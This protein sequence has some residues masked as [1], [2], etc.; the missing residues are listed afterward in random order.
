MRV[1]AISDTHCALDDIGPMLPPGDVLVHAGDLTMRGSL[2]EV[3]HQLHVLAS[4]PYTVKVLVAGNHDWLF[5]RDPTTAQSLLRDVAAS[6]VVYLQDSSHVVDGVHFYGSPWQ[7]RFYDWAFNVDR[8]PAIRAYWD[9]IP[10]G[11]DVLVTHGPPL[12]YGDWVPRGEHVGCADLLD[13]VA[14]VRPRY[15]IFGHIHCDRGVRVGQG[16]VSATTF[17]NAACL[18]DRYDVVPTCGI[19]LD[20]K[21]P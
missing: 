5:E 2:K 18:D 8:G 15:H 9:R 17:V 12:Y 19:V 21:T 13:T 10:D 11:V 3:A 4:L 1:V 16:A 7:P 14:R 20:I 6:G